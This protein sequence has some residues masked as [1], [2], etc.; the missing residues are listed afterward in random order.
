FAARRWIV[1]RIPD[2]VIATQSITLMKDDLLLIT[3][4]CLMIASSLVMSNRSVTRSYPGRTRSL[5]LLP[6]GIFVGFVAGTT[7]IGG[8][9]MIVP[10]LTF[11]GLRLDTAI[12]TTLIIIAANSLVG[13]YGHLSN[14]AVDWAFLLGLTGCAY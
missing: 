12:G 1:E 10:A 7:G 2:V 3:F 5:H 8:G 13:F 6:S 9:F 14:H 4:S 11:A